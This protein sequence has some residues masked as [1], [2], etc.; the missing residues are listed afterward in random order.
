VKRIAKTNTP[1]NVGNAD[2]GGV[3]RIGISTNKKTSFLPN[4]PNKTTSVA[5]EYHISTNLITSLK[6]MR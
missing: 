2:N 5:T 3:K 6:I 1:N 4:F